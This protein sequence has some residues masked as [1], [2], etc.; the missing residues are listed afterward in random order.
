M[1]KN[2]LECWCD[3]SQRKTRPPST[4]DVGTEEEQETKTKNRKQR[5][6]KQER[7]SCDEKRESETEKERA[8]GDPKQQTC[9]KVI[10]MF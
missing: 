2:G 8:S 1:I 6:N 5:V 10:T 7:N 3:D 4:L 9:K